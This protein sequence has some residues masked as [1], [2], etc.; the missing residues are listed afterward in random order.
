MGAVIAGPRPPLAERG[1]RLR[2][3]NAGLDMAQHC[4]TAAVSPASSVLHRV[5]LP[6]MCGRTGLLS[7]SKSQFPLHKVVTEVAALR[8]SWWLGLSKP[9]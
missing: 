6:L 3:W 4:Q 7:L 8:F 2:S 1:L 5:P 9:V